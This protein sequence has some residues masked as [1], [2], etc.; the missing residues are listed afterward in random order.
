MVSRMIPT[1]KRAS[2]VIGSSRHTLAAHL[3]GGRDS[4]VD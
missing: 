1:I 3:A 2:R 4:V